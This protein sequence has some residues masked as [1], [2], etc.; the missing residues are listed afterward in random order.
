MPTIKYGQILLYCH[1]NKIKKGSDFQFLV[2]NQFP[3]SR[4]EPK[5]CQKCLFCSTLY[6]TKFH[7]ESTQDS[8]EISIS[9]TTLFHY[10][11]MLMMISQILKY[12]NF[13]K[14][15]KSG[16]FKNE[17]VFFQIKQENAVRCNS[18]DNLLQLSFSSKISIFSEAYI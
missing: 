11:A 1:F 2:P 3:V 6:L 13:T 9:V 15:K 5:T 18:C 7:F 8:K 16:Y 10:V 12:V 17:T 14:T 4:I